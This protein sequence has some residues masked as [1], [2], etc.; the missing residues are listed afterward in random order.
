MVGFSPRV[1]SAG[2]VLALGAIWL[3][4]QAPPPPDPTAAPAPLLT[5]QQLDNLVA[6]VAL[7]PDPLLS[8][9][10]VACTYPLELVQA[11]QWLQQ[12]RSLSG[13]QLLDNARAQGWDASVSALVALPDVL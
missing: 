12:N 13:Q 8:Q 6:P 4:A 2:L 11:Q 1:F 7:Y 5:P 9:V 10:L 3:P